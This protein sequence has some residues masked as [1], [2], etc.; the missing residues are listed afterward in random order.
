MTRQPLKVR[1]MRGTVEFL[2]RHPTL[3]KAFFW[4]NFYGLRL[5]KPVEYLLLR[6]LMDCKSVLDLGCGRHSMVPILPKSVNTVGVEF[7]EPHLDEARESARHSS[8]VHAD[9]TKADFPEKSF[10]A[11]VMLDVIEHLPKAQGEALLSS[12]QRWARKKI[13]IFTPNGF[14]HQHEYDENPLMEHLSGWEP[15][16]F[17]RLGFNKVFGVRG[18]KELK[19]DCHEHGHGCEC[20]VDS[21]ADITQI[22]TYHVPQWAFQLFC[23][24]E[25]AR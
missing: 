8:Y 24:K 12:M 13:V 11:V 14:V 5:A 9:I 19:K 25:L 7:F 22:V 23:V 1:L 21:V 6:E 18:F 15:G 16:D 17:R 4:L 10:D 20:E 3:R 2:G